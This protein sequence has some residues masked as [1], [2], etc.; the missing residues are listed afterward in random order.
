MRKP[1]TNLIPIVLVLLA[2]LPLAA[3]K[4]ELVAAQSADEEGGEATEKP[5]EVQ[6]RFVDNGDGTVRDTNTG[7][8][9]LKDA[10][11]AE[12]KDTDSEGQADWE[13]A[14]AATKALASG[15]C[16]LS[17][18]SKAGDWRLPE[19]LEFCSAWEGRQTICPAEAAPTSLIDRSLSGAPYLPNAAGTGLWSEGDAFVGVQSFTYWSATEDG[20]G[21]AWGA[22]LLGGG[23]GRVG[24]GRCHVWPVRSG[25]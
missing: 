19:I 7:L 3:C 18:G 11:C 22:S 8:I 10:N 24:T 21:S 6:G 14:K 17:D 4:R 20:A 16:G 25:Q 13:T 12:L 15:N 9:W 1:V 2:L 5:A 23:V